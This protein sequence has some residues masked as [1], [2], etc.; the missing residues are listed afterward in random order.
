MGTVVKSVDSNMIA[1]FVFI[2][3]C[4]TVVKLIFKKMVIDANMGQHDI[5]DGIV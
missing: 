2:F 1:F 3:N 5:N 4:L